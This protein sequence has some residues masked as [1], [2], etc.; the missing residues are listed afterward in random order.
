VVLLCTLLLTSCK[1]FLSQEQRDS[2]TASIQRDYEDG[3]ITRAE[4]DLA[5]E[6]LNQDASDTDFGPYGVSIVNLLLALAGAKYM[7]SRQASTG[8]VIETR[9]PKSKVEPFDV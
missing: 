3:N 6:K 4:R 2:I 5:I 9:T 7:V 8:P 1:S